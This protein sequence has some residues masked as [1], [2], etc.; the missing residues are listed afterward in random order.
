[1]ECRQAENFALE[2]A[3]RE[4]ERNAYTSRM[5]GCLFKVCAAEVVSPKYLSNFIEK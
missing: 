2:E 1:M 5:N 4:G 3:W